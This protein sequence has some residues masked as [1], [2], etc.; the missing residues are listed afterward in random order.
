MPYV[1]AFDFE[2]A[3]GIP[4]RHAFTQLGAVIMNV[5]NDEIVAEFNSYSNMKGYE[6]DERCVNEFWKKYPKRF[7][8]TKREV[9]RATLNPYQVVGG[10]IEWVQFNCANLKDVYLLTD[11]AAFDAGILRYFSVGQDI[12]YIFG[13]YRP[14][15][16]S[17][18]YYAG[19]ARTKVTPATLGQ[20][21]KRLAMDR[22][23]RERA[24]YNL[25]QVEDFPQHPVSHDHNPVNDAK[26]MAWNWC[27]LQRLL[28]T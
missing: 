12:L 23:N 14:I 20:S 28:T 21:S 22:L 6:W 3:G 9:D 24:L 16:E 4:S 10:F 1:V 26:V 8:E 5:D 25:A 7:E 15:V 2:S 11:N 18:R 27:H 13:E 17:S 19:I